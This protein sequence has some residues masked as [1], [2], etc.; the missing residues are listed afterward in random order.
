MSFVASESLSDQLII[1]MYV[2]DVHQAEPIIPPFAHSVFVIQ[3]AH[4]VGMVLLVE[5]IVF[6]SFIGKGLCFLSVDFT[7]PK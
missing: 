5:K 1:G 7:S 6:D 3:S 2:G 4:L